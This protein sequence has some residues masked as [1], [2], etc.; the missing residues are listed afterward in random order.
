MAATAASG[1][2]DAAVWVIRVAGL[3]R[4]ALQLEGAA[5][6]VLNARFR[7][8][9]FVIWKW[10]PWRSTKP[11]LGEPLWFG[12]CWVLTFVAIACSALAEAVFSFPARGRRVHNA[13]YFA[14]HVVVIC[15]EGA[16]LMQ[17]RVSSGLAGSVQAVQR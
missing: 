12:W 17:R 11:C 15:N 14:D 1:C 13:S 7:L 10:K 5:R 16:V 2:N 4:P 6:H 8:Q 3:A 9:R